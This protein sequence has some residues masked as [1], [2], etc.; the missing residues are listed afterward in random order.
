M[1]R[2]ILLYLLLYAELALAFPDMVRHGYATC[3]SCHVSPSGGGVLNAYGRSVSSELISTYRNEKLS[4]YFIPKLPAWFS[5]GGDV[6][7][8]NVSSEAYN[9]KYHRHFLMQSDLEISV[10]PVPGLTIVGAVG[11]YNV[12]FPEKNTRKIEAEQRRNYVLLD[13]GRNFSF[14]LGRYIP[15]YGIAYPDHTLAT[16]G[17]LGFSQ[18]QETN[19]IETSFRNKWGEIFLTGVNGREGSVTNSTKGYRY[20]EI[21]NGRSGLVGR[22]NIPIGRTSSAGFSAARFTNRGSK[23]FETLYGIHGVLTPLIVFPWIY[24][25]F[26][27]D[28]LLETGKKRDTIWVVRQGVEIVRGVHVSATYEGI[29]S[30]YSAWRYTLQL[31]PISHL[32]L[33]AEYQRKVPY[34][35]GVL[36]ES[37]VFLAHWYF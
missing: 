26:E 20:K 4:R 28:Q 7:Y 3:N 36:S 32:E 23:T 2:F 19:N 15:T 18:G 10:S 21:G 37:F 35:R 31:F 24:T 30:S 27:V 22:I 17:R 6:R 16:R 5:F 33:S 12:N 8:V 29:R 34:P 13:V 25:M 11:V 9:F 14:R 1:K